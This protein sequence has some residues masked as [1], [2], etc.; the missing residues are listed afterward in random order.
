M[1]HQCDGG[2]RSV[3][4]SITRGDR[5]SVLASFKGANLDNDVR[6]SHGTLRMFNPLVRLFDQ[7][8]TRGMTAPPLNNY[9]GQSLVGKERVKAI[10]VELSQPSGDGRIPKGLPKLWLMPK[11]QK[12]KSTSLRS[13][14]PYQRERVVRYKEL[15]AELES[16]NKQCLLR[17]VRKLF[18]KLGHTL[19]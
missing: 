4:R 18:S 2:S 10:G 15:I 8:L 14:S 6:V 3:R 16:D 19:N 7:I 5:C 11:P 17:T 1:R 9:K 12:E 13:T